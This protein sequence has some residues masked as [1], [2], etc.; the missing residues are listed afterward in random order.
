MTQLTETSQGYEYKVKTLF[1][2]GNEYPAIVVYLPNLEPIQIDVK[3]IFQEAEQQVRKTTG[4][5]LHEQVYF[6]VLD[7]P[8]QICEQAYIRSPG[9]EG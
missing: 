9:A 1:R 5:G 7:S 6:I 8:E 4:K 2:D 3:R